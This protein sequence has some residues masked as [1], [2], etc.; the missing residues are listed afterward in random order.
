MT[1]GRKQDACHRP[2]DQSFGQS[3]E[4]MDRIESM[5]HG[6]PHRFREQP[7][8]DR[9]RFGP[10][11]RHATKIDSVDGIRMRGVDFGGA[12]NVGGDDVDF[13]APNRLYTSAAQ[14]AVPPW[15]AG[16]AP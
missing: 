4:S 16:T 14:T 10:Q 3:P 7:E 6:Q 5:G 12:R 15:S 13:L 11:P 8:I 9:Q 1:T 2:S